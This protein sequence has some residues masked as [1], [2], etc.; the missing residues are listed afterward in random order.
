MRRLRCKTDSRKSF[1]IARR[2][3][4]LIGCVSHLPAIDLIAGCATS[5]P[6]K[7]LR[8]PDQSDNL[9]EKRST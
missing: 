3:S 2:R 1:H 5:L 4:S 7:L 6:L 8:S 9:F